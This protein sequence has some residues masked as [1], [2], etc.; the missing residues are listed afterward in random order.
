MAN[1]ST[2]APPWLQR[3]DWHNGTPRQS[4][5]ATLTTSSSILSPDVMGRA[6]NQAPD[7]LVAVARSLVHA[8]GSRAVSSKTLEVACTRGLSQALCCKLPSG[9]IPRSSGKPLQ[10]WNA[11][12]SGGACRHCWRSR[13]LCCGRL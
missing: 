7:S 9:W 3:C 4:P 10:D 12:R 1:S 11:L 6:C 8:R 13:C 5:T 2:N